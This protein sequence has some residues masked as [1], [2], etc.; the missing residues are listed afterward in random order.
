VARLSNV[1]ATRH[2][3]ELSE[4]TRVVFLSTDLVFDGAKGGYTEDDAVHPLSVYAET[5]VEAESLVRTHPRHLIVRTSLNYGHT[6][7]ANRS[8]NEDMARA[9]EAGKLLSL[10]TDEFRCPIPASVTARALWELLD[11]EIVG[12]FHLAGA[13]RLSR[14]EIGN[15]LA[16]RNRKYNPRLEPSSLK[17]YRGAPRPPDI[18]LDCSRVQKQLSFALPRF[19]EWLEIH[20]PGR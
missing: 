19:S 6:A 1:E 2:L 9:W 7:G 13:E 16:P 5:K 17:T 18:A 3:V 11:Q 4:D 14:W 10:F 8:F 12:T 20:E 15:L